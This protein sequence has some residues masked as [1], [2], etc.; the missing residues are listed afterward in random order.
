[1]KHD[2]TVGLVEFHNPDFVKKSHW[3]TKG[4]RHMADVPA[5]MLPIIEPWLV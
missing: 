5:A 3:Q 2:A 1:M 4:E